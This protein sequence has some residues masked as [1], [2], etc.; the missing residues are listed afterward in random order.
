M[1]K[2]IS[3][4]PNYNVLAKLQVGPSFLFMPRPHLSRGDEG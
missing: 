4:L 2:R 1:I 3:H